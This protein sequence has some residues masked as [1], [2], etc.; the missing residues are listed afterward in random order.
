MRL[1]LSTIILVCAIFIAGR[2]GLVALIAKGY[3]GLTV[4]FMLVYI[5]PLLTYGVWRLTIDRAHFEKS[6]STS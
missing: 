5:V 6:D 1:A 3:R 2:F 4:L